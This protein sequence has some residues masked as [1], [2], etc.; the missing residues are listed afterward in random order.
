[1]SGS[2]SFMSSN[3]SAASFFANSSCPTKSSSGDRRLSSLLTYTERAGKRDIVNIDQQ[4]RRLLRQK[5]ELRGQ[6]DVQFK[7]ISSGMCPV[8]LVYTVDL[9]SLLNSSAS[10]YII[11][12]YI[13]YIIFIF[14]YGTCAICCGEVA[15]LAWCMDASW[16]SNSPCRATSCFSL[17]AKGP[18]S[19]SCAGMGRDVEEAG[20][21]GRR[22]R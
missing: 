18:T 13:I 12:V 21:E 14:K 17:P 19:R 3:K 2:S 16:V 5:R 8:C 9:Y 6:Q 10:I 11:N 15:L 1:M 22:S 20:R 4:A 7:I